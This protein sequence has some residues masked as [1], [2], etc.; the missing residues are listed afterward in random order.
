MK[1]VIIVVSL[2]ILIPYFVVT[3]FIKDENVK[4]EVVTNNIVRVKREKTKEIINVPLE[5][6]VV[7][8]LAG[9]MP[10]SF[11]NE[12]LK[13]QAVAARSFV[14]RKMQMNTKKDYDV[15]DTISDQ[16]YLDDETLKKNWQK[17]YE[18][19]MNKMRQAVID[20]KGEYLTYDDEVI[21]AFFFST[22]SGKTENSEEVFTS[23]EPYLVSVD[24]SW[25]NISPVFS[26]SKT[27]SLSDFYTKLNL[28]Y[29]KNLNYKIKD[30][31]KS[32]TIK[33]VII[34]GTTFK[35][36]TVRKKLDLRSA[37]FTIEQNDSNVIIGT[38]G[39]GHGVGMS[40]YGALAMAKLGKKYDEIL[41]HYY[42][43]VEITKM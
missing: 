5:E 7:H 25:D 13:A 33:N 42:T 4:F 15:V 38:K 21:Q 28:K 11:E 40:Q 29:Q 20:T 24:S 34:N 37:N 22:S 26:D 12:A 18:K 32:G 16:V 23:A 3:L 27:M 14:I 6:Y 1:K 9:E 2:I 30:Y 17:N 39:F 43:G 35:A 8:V 36:T 10:V 41:K 19:N 31:N